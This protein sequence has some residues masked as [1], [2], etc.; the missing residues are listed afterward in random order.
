MG[1]SQ[2]RDQTRV[3]CIGRWILNHCTT[4]EVPRM[5]S[6]SQGSLTLILLSP[7]FFWP[8]H[9]ACGVLVPQPEIEPWP[10]QWKCWVLTTGPPG[11]SL[12]E[13]LLPCIQGL[14]HGHFRGLLCL[15]HGSK[16]YEV[17]GGNVIII[18]DYSWEVWEENERFQGN[19]GPRKAFA[20]F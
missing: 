10:W 8:C 18:I 2:T 5:I 20:F 17:W 6:S 11:N 3:P 7:F 1:S 9:E 15:S 12:A 19:T 14:R 16:K 13:S 4:R